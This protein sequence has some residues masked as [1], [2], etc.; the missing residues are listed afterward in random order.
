MSNKTELQSNNIELQEILDSINAL[1]DADT[2]AKTPIAWLDVYFNR[3]LTYNIPVP[4][5]G[6]SNGKAMFTITGAQYNSTTPTVDSVYYVD[7]TNSANND[8][9]SSTV[10][11]IDSNINYSTW[12]ITISAISKVNAT[13]DV[14]ISQS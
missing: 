8:T 3:T 2:S 9:G 14:E 10:K 12:L 1:P 6:G 13:Y 11:L 5:F 7:P 4:L